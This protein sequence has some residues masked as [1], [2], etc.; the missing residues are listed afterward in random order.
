MFHFHLMSSLYYSL[1]PVSSCLH[2]P[3]RSLRLDQLLLRV[4]HLVLLLLSLLLALPPHLTGYPPS[5]QSLP[6]LPLLPVS[7]AQGVG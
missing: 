3:S 4:N 5:R 1:L 7:P 6:P 2:S